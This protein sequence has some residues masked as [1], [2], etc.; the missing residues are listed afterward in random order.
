MYGMFDGLATLA[1]IG[2]VAIVA[3]LIALPFGIYWL[4]NHVQVVI[5]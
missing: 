1:L 4:I 2:I 5:R 3:A